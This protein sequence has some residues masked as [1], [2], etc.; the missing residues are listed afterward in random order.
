M[1]PDK[2]I[3]AMAA[4][5]EA[6]DKFGEDEGEVVERVL[7][8]AGSRYGVNIGPAR[9][10]RVKLPATATGQRAAAVDADFEDI[11]DLYAAAN[12]KTAPDR[13]LVASY[14][15]TTGE[16]QAEFAS[17]DVNR[18]LKNLGHG[19]SNITD[20]LSS[21][22]KRKPSLV[23]QTAKSGKARQARK[24]YKLTRAGLDAVSTMIASSAVEQE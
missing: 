16:G 3:S 1:S 6:L 14:W 21:L 22:T 7:K 5:A 10:E 11:A 12:P 4:I 19:V 23:M 18:H 20:A 17:Q 9:S 8:W 2:E 15:I 24:R 13:A